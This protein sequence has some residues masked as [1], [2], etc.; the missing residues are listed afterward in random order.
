MSDKKTDLQS[1]MQ[2]TGRQIRELSHLI[3]I[4]E[5]IKEA[6]N[7]NNNRFAELSKQM[8]IS[9]S[10]LYSYGTKSTTHAVKRNLRNIAQFLGMT[11]IEE[12][13][14]YDGQGGGEPVAEFAEAKHE[15]LY[16]ALKALNPELRDMPDS[17]LKA[18]NANDL[19]KIAIKP[20]LQ[21][22]IRKNTNIREGMMAEGEMKSKA[23]EMHMI[24]VIDEENATDFNRT[25]NDTKMYM[26]P[27]HRLRDKENLLGIKLKMD[28][29]KVISPDEP[30]KLKPMPNPY[31]K[32][33]LFAKGSTMVVDLNPD[34]IMPGDAIMLMM[35]NGETHFGILDELN[36][37]SDDNGPYCILNRFGKDTGLKDKK[38]ISDDKTI[39]EVLDARHSAGDDH[40][41]M[42]SSD[43]MANWFKI[44][45]WEVF[46][47]GA[48][49]PF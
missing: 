24:P 21:N 45:H 39:Q 23:L 37:S 6:L 35:T 4:G 44:V 9:K 28:D 14:E 11:Y 25:M 27:P 5:S 19:L 33:R 20:T 49:L 32:Q 1:K 42:S 7:L 38:F 17:E 18:M 13:D 22:A 46:P 26:L 31:L 36:T 30:G 43:I 2:E 41:D 29:I 10:S 3:K 8:N 48:T 16:R 34:N 15:G 40:P 12:Y 47:Y